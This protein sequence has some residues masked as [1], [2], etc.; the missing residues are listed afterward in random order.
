VIASDWN[1]GS[2]PMGDLLTQ[3][4]LLSNFEKLTFAETIAGITFRAAY[5]L[6]IYDRGMLSQGKLADM[7]SFPT[8]DH[9]EILYN[10]GMLKPDMI[11]KNGNLF[12]KKSQ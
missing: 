1:P 10:Q 6:G 2:A 11:W 5:A 12:T 9:R 8:D 3:S 4:A 7:I